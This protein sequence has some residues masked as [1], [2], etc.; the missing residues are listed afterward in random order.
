MNL[1]LLVLIITIT[2]AIVNFVVGAR[3]DGR[4]K[5]FAHS[6]RAKVV[7]FIVKSMLV[8]SDRIRLTIS[9]SKYTVFGD[10][11]FLFC[12]YTMSITTIEIISSL[13]ICSSTDNYQFFGTKMWKIAHLTDDMKDLYV[14]S[15]A[16]SQTCNPSK[17]TE[18]TVGRMAGPVSGSD[19]GFSKGIPS[20]EACRWNRC[21]RVCKRPWSD[22]RWESRPHA[23]RR[24]SA[25]GPRSPSPPAAPPLRSASAWSS[26]CLWTSAACLLAWSLH[27]QLH[28]MYCTLTE[29]CIVFY[30]RIIIFSWQIHIF[31]V[32]IILRDRCTTVGNKEKIQ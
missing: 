4:V 3:V 18:K 6:P 24:P 15:N 30:N 11:Q 5:R 13:I 8:T 28:I 2:F 27:T 9:G 23:T 1:T 29:N 16:M 17:C 31:S 20:R 22:R 21:R 14:I 10:F 12:Q 25:P 32:M 7:C 19:R 26:A